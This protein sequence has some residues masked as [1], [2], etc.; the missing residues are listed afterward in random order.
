[1]PDGGEDGRI[2]WTGG[3]NHIDHLPGCLFGLILT[4]RFVLPGILYFTFKSGYCHYCPQCR[5]Q[6]AA[7]NQGGILAFLLHG[8]LL[9][10]GHPEFRL[11]TSPVLLGLILV[12]SLA[13]GWY[14]LGF[15]RETVPHSGAAS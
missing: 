3:T 6:I 11:P 9:L 4:F 12:V 2:Q 14:T 10:L 7:D 5:L 15:L 8:T 1:V 13:Q